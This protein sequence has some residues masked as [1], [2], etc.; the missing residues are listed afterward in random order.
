[1]VSPVRTLRDIIALLLL[2]VLVGGGAWY[3]RETRRR[4][5]AVQAVAGDVRRIEL[6]VKFRAAT[7]GAELN[8]RGWPLTVD[9]AWFAEN[10]PLNQLL[11]ADHPWLE[12]AGAEDAS[13]THPEARMAVD[14]SVAAFWYNPAQGIVRAR[15]PVMLSDADATV[16]YNTVNG[17]NL[18]SMFWI[19]PRTSTPTDP[20]PTR[21]AETSDRAAPTR[22]SDREPV[23]GSAV[24]P[25][26]PVIDA[27]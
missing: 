4:D 2:V 16:L 14:P 13:L 20:R 26:A 21:D 5:A 15:V 24:R 8:A 12:V 6:E 19:E 1:M 18:P 9:P 3:V 27:K 11:P 17:T 25:T 7:N 22:P 23:V 10:P